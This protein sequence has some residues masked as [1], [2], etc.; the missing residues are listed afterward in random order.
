MTTQNYWPGTNIPK[1]HGNAFDWKGK[2]SVIVNQYDVICSN[3]AKKAHMGVKES[4]FF[5]TYSLAKPGGV[6][7]N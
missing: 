6:A 5:S 3:N 4:K 2:Q 7:S 1:S